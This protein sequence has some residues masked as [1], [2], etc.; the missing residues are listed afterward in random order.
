MLD[1][2]IQKFFCR[3]FILVFSLILIP[4]QLSA[5]Y[6]STILHYDDNMR[7][8]YHSD[9]DGN[10]IPDFSHA[11]YRGGGV[12]IPVVETVLEISPITGDNTAHIQAAIDNVSAMTLNSNGFRGAVLLKPGLYPIDG[13]IYIKKSGVVLRGSGDGPTP[14]DNTIIIGRGTD[15]RTLVVIGG[16]DISLWKEEVPGSRVNITSEY[17]PVGS[18]TIEVEN[19][20]AYHVGDNI[21]IR[22]PSTQ[23]WI[24][25]VRGGDTGIDEPWKPGEID[26]YFNSFVTAVEGK[27]IQLDV[28]L[29]H[30]LDRSLSQ[31]YA[32][33]FTRKN[34]MTE[35]G[36]ENLRIDIVTAGP[37]D[38][39][40]PWYGVR[41][42]GVED[43]WAKN[44]TVN[45]FA[46][47]GFI[48]EGTTRTTVLNCQA[49]EPHSAVEA[50]RR[51]NFHVA[52]AC[53]NVLFKDCHSTESRHAF[54]SNGASTVAGMVF[55]GCSSEQAHT[56]SEGHR[57]WGSGFLW[58]N[59]S[60]HST[61][62]DR[63]LG[64][65]NRGDYGTGHGWTGTNQVAWNIYAPNNQIV[66]QKPP[67]GQ[68]YAIACDATVD[69]NGPYSQPAGYIEGTGEISEIT[70]LY[71]AQLAERLTYGIRPDTPG[72]LKLTSY[73]YSNTSKYINL[74]WLD[75]AMDENRYVLERSSDGG[76][77]FM[78]IAQL[79]ENTESYSDEDSKL[80][81]RVYQ[82]RL[83]AIND[84]GS[85]AWS[86]LLSVDL[87]SSADLINTTFSVTEDAYVRGGDSFDLNYGAATD[88]VV[89]QGSVENFFRKTLIKI[90]LNGENIV[91]EDI[92][93]AMLKLY[94]FNTDYCIITASEIDD[95]W[96]E[97][98]INWANAPVTG[99]N[100]SSAVISSGDMY[101][102]WDITNYLKSQ[103]I[104][105]GVVSVC[106][107]D[108]TAANVNV[109]FK[110]KE[111]ADHC[112]ELVI[113]VE[114]KLNYFPDFSKKFK[115]SI[116]PNPATEVL[117]VATV[118]FRIDKL[119]IYNITGRMLLIQYD[120][121]NLVSF[122]IDHLENG[123]YLL[124]AE[125]DFGTYTHKFI[126]ARL[127]NI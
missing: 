77:T 113:S 43:C 97:S 84:I 123:I 101:Y 10:R 6:Q 22:H 23:S 94:A 81:A 64:L 5:Q 56:A 74:A 119:A 16:N 20:S 1:Y 91:G 118:D 87:T 121:E 69:N 42:K 53:N 51:Y 117:N 125:G 89:K 72:K 116:Y 127:G 50:S 26:M 112:P 49:I 57:R 76:L 52:A 71:E 12:D 80:E 15:K 39:N 21:I 48:L 73:S 120:V 9:E 66:I 45:H 67:I 85:S 33:I 30:E 68:N 114:D 41:F 47:A 7:L 14:I 70:S 79:A 105:D 60:F 122:D 25:A 115:L 44:V 24:D 99:D 29:Y 27:K 78:Q 34:L 59:T 61:N 102:E 110:S 58:D 54:V 62:T 35:M 90:D 92:V 108:Q 75:I 18:R 38:E 40:H 17:L 100:I 4:N 109:N 19:A 104:Q 83:K 126:K 111:A 55:T 65:Y 3:L 106:L 37:E 124:K 11:G 103:L 13:T 107:Q 46:Q 32:W 93:K 98:T 95:N 2:I 36:I 88:L 86:N 31:S 96:T 63:V 82:Y 8:V 28:P